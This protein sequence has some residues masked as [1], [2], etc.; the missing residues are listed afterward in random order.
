MDFRL[1]N[2]ADQPIGTLARSEIAARLGSDKRDRLT[3]QCRSC[4]FRFARN[5]GCPKHRILTSR[6]GEPGH[7]YF[8][9][10]HIMF[11]RHLAAR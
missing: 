10:S 4:E 8:C 11:F 1:G 2:I 5:G 7:N 6:A 9:E 3:A